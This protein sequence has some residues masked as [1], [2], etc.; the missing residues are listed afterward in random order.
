[1]V[2]AA[3]G[4]LLEAQPAF[5]PGSPEFSVAELEAA[6]AAISAIDI[7]VDNVFDLNDP[8]ENRRIYRW[9]NRVH[10]R[11]RPQVIA[12]IL[13][14]E[15]NDVLSGRLLEETERLLRER[16][17]VADAEI[18]V[19]GFDPATNAALVEVWTRDAWSL[20]PEL[21]LSRGGGETEYAIGLTEDNLLGLGKGM[22]VAYDSDVD[23]D[24]RLFSYS[25][26]NLAGSRS[27]LSVSFADRSDG[28]GIDIATGRPFFALDTRWAIESRFIDDERIDSIYDL[29]KVIDEFRHDTRFFSVQGGRSRGM[30]NGVT[31]RWFAGMTYDDQEFQAAAGRPNP[32][33]L[34]PDN[35][36][37]VYPWV[38]MQIITE[39]YRQVTELNDMGRTEDIA[40]GLNLSASIGFAM[41]GL[42]SDRDATLVNFSASRGW[43][44]GGPG[45]LL[46]FEASASAREEHAGARNSVVKLSGE[47]FQRN[48]GDQ[49]FIA[50][51][52]TVFGSALDAER[53]VLLG[54]DSGL[55]G[56]PIRYQSGEN[57][58]L[59]TLEQRFFTDWYPF[60]LIRVGYAFFLDAGRVWGND[61]RGTPNLGRLYDV[62]VGLRLSS[63][64]S[65]GRSIVH[66]DL[67]F[68]VNA[69]ADIDNMQISV[70]R[71]SSF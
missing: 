24:T 51:L 16:A 8:D 30:V 68:P 20:D 11:T 71:K 35:R 38:G 7:R 26:G 6:G 53:Q 43:E 27:K 21:K 17:F 41:T 25:D 5:D 52:K 3:S 55:R 48:L 2:L 57:S 44:P 66:I 45:S 37:L 67:A 59:L 34:L 9:A 18:S 70:E 19:T 58:V 23:R 46:L 14:F 12:D 4:C 40:L 60:N 10:R 28:R 15:E 32:V 29:G 62:G 50:S 39:D 31:Q 69:P 47:Y 22:T 65:S 63:P 61:P 56:Y 49:L 36:K 54:G 13:L 1:V 42:G 64:K 33:L